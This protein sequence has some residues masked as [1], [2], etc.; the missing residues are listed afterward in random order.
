MLCGCASGT[1]GVYNIHTEKEIPISDSKYKDDH[2]MCYQ[3]ARNSCLGK[4]TRDGSF[5]QCVYHETE[6]CMRQKGYRDFR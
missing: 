3:G 2:S 4:S 5:S 1:R 6:R